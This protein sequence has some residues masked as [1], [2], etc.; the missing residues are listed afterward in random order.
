MQDPVR[1]ASIE[2]GAKKMVASEAIGMRLGLGGN[3][4]LTIGEKDLV[5]FDPDGKKHN[6]S[7]N[8]KASSGKQLLDDLSCFNCLPLGGAD[9]KGKHTIPLYNV[10]WA[11]LR[12]DSLVVDYAAPRKSSLKLQKWTFALPTPEVEAGGPSPETFVSA[13]IAAAYGE[14]KPRKRAYVLINPNSGP[15][16]AVGKWKKHVKPIFEAARMEMDVVNLSRG[17]EATELSEKADLDK[18]DTIMAL[19]GDGTPFEIFNGLGK[20]PDAAKAL[21]KIAVSHIPCG[22]GNAFSLNCNGTNDAGLSALAVVK[23]VVM[24]LDLVSITQGDRRILSFLSQ[25]LGL[26]AESDLGTEN[27]RWMG[28]TRFE[29]GL[30]TRVFKKKSYPFDLSVKLEIEGKEM[31]KQHYKKYASDSA[32]LNVDAEVTAAGEEG[33]PKLKYGTVQDEIPGDWQ[34]ASHD[35]I[36]TF[37]VGNMAYMSPD[38]NFFTA[39]VPTDGL[40]DLVMIPADISP[41]A[42]TKALLAVESGKFFD[43]PHVTYKKISA[44]RITP[45][46]QETGY[47][48]IDGERIPFEPFQAEIHRG[49]GRVISKKGVYEAEGPAGWEKA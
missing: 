16:G 30:A 42:V 13:L 3:K 5:L 31:I 35:N 29:V 32:L 21:A 43:N 9:G 46:N 28:N 48:S 40:M 19:S 41:V 27:M 34:T 26:I 10:L 38:A 20:R 17:G 15:G 11:E 8:G 4:T 2:N 24:P 23:G 37:Y 44:Y 36:G 14:A 39:A 49:L 33:L 25:A 47:I 6:K 18:Y 12:D 45:R 7:S 1:L 22:S